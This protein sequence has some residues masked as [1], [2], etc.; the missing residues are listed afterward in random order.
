MGVKH[1][2]DSR[3]TGFGEE[4]LLAT[5]GEGVDVVLN[6][7]TSEG[8]IDASLS[9]LA[10]GGRFVELARRDILSP[11]EMAEIRPDVSYDILELDVLKKTDPAWVGR[12]LREVMAGISSGEL[13]PLVHSRWPLAEAGA[14]LGF[15]RAARHLGK[16]VVTV[17]P[18]AQGHL[19][20]DRTY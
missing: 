13:R 11:E 3:Q 5:G 12:V 1:I 10:Q 15:M 14:A 9:C 18:L 19:R 17:N 8:F 7:L 6:S 2:F 20:E 16:I 4:I